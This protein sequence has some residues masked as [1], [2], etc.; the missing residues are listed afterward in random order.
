ME[1]FII[2]F[3]SHQDYPNDNRILNVCLTEDIANEKLLEYEKNEAR[4]YV[5]YF[6]SNYDVEIGNWNVSVFKATPKKQQ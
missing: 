3:H 5:E 4:S 2:M 1:V 6:I